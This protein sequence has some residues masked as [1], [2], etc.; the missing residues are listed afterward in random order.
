MKS[1][2]ITTRSISF[3]RLRKGKL[4]E[5]SIPFGSE[6]L[7]PFISYLLE[8]VHLIDA[9]TAVYLQTSS[10]PFICTLGSEGE[11][12]AEEIKQKAIMLGLS[13]KPNTKES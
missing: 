13:V 2:D 6:S 10:K 5:V 9:I 4:F 11:E 1:Q 3:Q 7:N 12:L 8:D